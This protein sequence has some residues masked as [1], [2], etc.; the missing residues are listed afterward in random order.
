MINA[1]YHLKP[2]T[3]KFDFPSWSWTGWKGAIKMTSYQNPDPE[4]RLVTTAGDSIP[5]DE[6]IEEFDANYPPDVKP[7]IERDV[8]YFLLPP[9]TLGASEASRGLLLDRVHGVGSDWGCR[10]G[11][12]Q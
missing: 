12:F 2:G 5:L 1:W 9:R 6:Y 7:V 8:T 4:L 10:Y 3:R 11:H